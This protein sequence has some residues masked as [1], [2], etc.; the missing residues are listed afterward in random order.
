MTINYLVKT[1]TE[2]VKVLGS[3]SPFQFLILVSS[4]VVSQFVP[5]VSRS[6]RD[7]DRKK[8]IKET[9]NKSEKDT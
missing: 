9:R 8:C 4:I 5:F 6:I 1:K 3:S 7:P 2:G